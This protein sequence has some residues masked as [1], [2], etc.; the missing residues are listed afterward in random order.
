MKTVNAKQKELTRAFFKAFTPKPVLKGSQ[1]ADRYRYV[2]ASTSPEPGRWVSSRTPYLTEILDAC[3]DRRVE[4]VYIMAASQIGKSELLLNIMGYYIH[5]EPSPVLFIQPTDETAKAFSK[6]RIDPTIKASPVLREIVVEDSKG[7]ERQ[8]NN[9]VLNKTFVGGYLAIIGAVSTSKLAS[10][11]IR[12][13]LMDEIDRFNNTAEGSPIK[14]ARQRTSNFG[15]RKIIG[16]STP[17]I[18]NEDDPK[19]TISKEFELS[20]KREFKVMCPHCEQRFV[21]KWE[22]VRWDKNEKGEV[23]EDTIGLFCPNCKAKVRGAGKP[24]PSLIESGIWEPTAK[25]KIRGYHVNALVSPWVHLSTLVTEFITASRNR[26]KEALRVFYN[27]RL[28]LPFEEYKT[29]MLKWEKLYKRCEYYPVDGFSS[30][31]LFLTAGVDVQRDRLEISIYGWGVGREAWLISH[32]Q[33]IGNPLEGEVW[34]ELDGIILHSKFLNEDKQPR[35]LVATF[36]DSG[37][38]VMTET[39][40]KYTRQRERYRVVAIKGQGGENKPFINRPSRQGNF[41]AL[42]YVLGV[43]AGKSIVTS[44]L[45][46]ETTGPMYMHF[47]KGENCV[48]EEFFKQLTA[49]VQRPKKNKDT[50]AVKMEWVKLR[51]RNEALDCAVYARAAMEALNPDFESIARSLQGNEND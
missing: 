37:D 49:E 48:D 30:S 29:A 11:P 50:G 10:R 22:Q 21:M 4:Q 32:R 20:D 8:S 43:D 3:T 45:D 34:K 46:L 26:D 27:L 18:K 51:E 41:K 7:I 40:Y 16:V 42:L 24:S 19:P 12:I 33:I 2:A 6:E 1:W 39:V 17:T 9:T 44:C 35:R 31:V 47:P 38:G 28:G 14:L 13:L 25:S 36:I 15:N 23:D 5:Q